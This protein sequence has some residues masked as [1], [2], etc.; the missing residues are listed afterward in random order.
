MTWNLLLTALTPVDV[1][2]SWVPHTP[3]SIEVYLGLVYWRRDEIRSHAQ[4]W[5]SLTIS[6]SERQYAG[7]LPRTNNDLSNG[8]PCVIQRLQLLP[9]THLDPK[10]SVRAIEPSRRQTSLC[11]VKGNIVKKPVHNARNL[12]SSTTTHRLPSLST[13]KFAR[14][15]VDGSCKILDTKFDD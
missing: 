8:Q 13:R 3:P 4:Y 6:H 11:P 1:D 9:A 14:V 15:T 7:Y 12:T 10:A 2:D 5:M